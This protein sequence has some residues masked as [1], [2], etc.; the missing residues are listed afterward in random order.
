VTTP[1]PGDLACFSWGQ[2]PFDHIGIA[3]AVPGQGFIRTVEGNF[4]PGN[5][6]T[7]CTR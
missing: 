3:T 6:E 5:G 1:Q 4:N 7:G 2:H